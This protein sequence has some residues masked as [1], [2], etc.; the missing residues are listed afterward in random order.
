MDLNG[1]VAFGKTTQMPEQNG[2]IPIAKLT[3]NG[4]I[5]LLFLQNDVQNIMQQ[6]FDKANPDLKLVFVD[7]E[8]QNPKTNEAGLLFQISNEREGV[9]ETTIVMALTLEKGI[10]YL[11]KDYDITRA[12][13]SMSGT[14]ASHCQQG[15]SCEL[16]QMG[17]N[18]WSC[19]SNNCIG[20]SDNGPQNYNYN[21][22]G[23]GYDGN[24]SCLY[25]PGSGAELMV[26]CPTEYFVEEIFPVDTIPNPHKSAEFITQFTVANYIFMWMWNNSD[27]KLKAN[28]L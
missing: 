19:T 6:L 8:V 16:K 13:N 11:P 1:N 22:E 15:G 3:G 25:K 17:L 24:Y 4:D 9:R 7:V 27:A 18:L 28:N 14:C 21:E 23:G 10:Y 26:C 20:S 5:E 12:G 2:M